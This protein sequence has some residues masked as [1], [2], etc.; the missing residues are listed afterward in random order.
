MLRADSNRQRSDFGRELLTVK[1]AERRKYEAQ[2]MVSDGRALEACMY[3]GCNTSESFRRDE[4]LNDSSIVLPSSCGVS[5]GLRIV[6]GGT[7]SI[8]RF[9]KL[10]LTFGRGL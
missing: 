2:S 1:V 3:S 6:F 9:G 10:F 7:L 4:R 8:R 5:N